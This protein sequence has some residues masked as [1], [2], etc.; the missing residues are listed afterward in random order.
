MMVASPGQ[1]SGRYQ[2]LPVCW[3]VSD[4]GPG[5]PLLKM[6]SCGTPLNTSS[7]SEASPFITTHCFLRCIY[8]AIQFNTLPLT[9]ISV[10]LPINLRWGTK[11]FQYSPS[12][13]S[14][15]DCT[16]FWVSIYMMMIRKS[17]MPYCNC[18]A[19]LWNV[20]NWLTGD[21]ASIES[22]R[23]K[24]PIRWTRAG[25]SSVDKVFGRVSY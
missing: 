9:P 3:I 1:N 16:S 25:F 10:S 19:E 4:P 23:I 8:S 17:S 20:N 13:N 21:K 14:L 24:A 18:Y 6:N 5:T 11:C 2:H 15:S 12:V 7:H 22:A